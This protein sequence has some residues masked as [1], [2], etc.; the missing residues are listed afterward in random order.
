M[1]RLVVGL[2]N[3]QQPQALVDRSRQPR[4]LRQPVHHPDP[5]R[6]QTPGSIAPLVMDIAASQ[7]RFR[8]SL[9]VAPAQPP[10]NPPLATCLSL[11]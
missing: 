6:A 1:I 3:L 5:A 2:V 9:P 11:L 10:P 7:H 4:L 8:L